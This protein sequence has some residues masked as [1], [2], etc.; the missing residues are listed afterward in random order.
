METLWPFPAKTTCS[1]AP[2]LPGLGPRG[3][4]KRARRHP[5]TRELALANGHGSKGVGPASAL[6]SPALAPFPDKMSR[7]WMDSLPSLKEPVLPTSPMTS[8]CPD[9]Q[10]CV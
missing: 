8:S 2:L 7:L 1:I 3:E 6:A 10:T 9:N 4:I 5:G